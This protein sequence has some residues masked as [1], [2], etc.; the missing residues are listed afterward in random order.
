[1]VSPRQDVKGRKKSYG[2]ASLSVDSNKVLYSI[3]SLQDWQAPIETV[4]LEVC[5]RKYT[6]K[7]S[8]VSIKTIVSHSYCV[9]ICICPGI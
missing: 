2:E 3:G 4:S 8:T 6:M 5:V 1:M 9:L 7:K